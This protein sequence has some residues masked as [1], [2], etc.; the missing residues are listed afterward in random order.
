MP[1]NTDEPNPVDVTL[2]YSRPLR[3][4]KLWLGFMTHGAEEFRQ[5]LEHNLLLA[6]QTYERASV[7]PSYRVLPHPPQ[8]S[9]VPIQHVP[10]GMTDPQLISEHNDKLCRAIAEDGRVY[11]SPANIDGHMWLRP[12]YTNFRTEAEDVD[13]LFE[14]IEELGAKIHA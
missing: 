10:H 14:V 4:L 8:L 13:V 2:E 12:C 1:H 5:A 9:I 11:L 6:R 7:N 3:A